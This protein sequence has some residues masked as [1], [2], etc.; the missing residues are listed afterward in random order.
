MTAVR[1]TIQIEQVRVG[2]LGL[3][4]ELEIPADAAAL[5]LFAHGSG[6]S[7]LS[8]RNRRV[9]QVLQ[10][11]GQATLLFDLLTE[12]EAADRRNVFDVA[13]LGGRVEQALDWVGQ[14]SAGA[15][16]GAIARLPVGL[17]GASTG[18]AAALVAAA[19]QPSRV[20]AV[21]SR[22]G[23]PDLAA[24]CL[25]R[26]EAPTLLIV[27]G[28]DPQVLDLNR[29]ALRLLGCRMSSP[30]WLRAGSTATWCAGAMRERRRDAVPSAD[31]RGAGSMSPGAIGGHAF[32]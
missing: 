4:G 9:A 12:R 25:D 8:E 5:V 17:F 28:A 6:S 32:R 14:Q 2:A 29:A 24:H 22:G 30:S 18:V 11:H 26:V 31:P 10:R 13:L 20:G 7:R 19:A 15:N 1:A 3:P 27:G 16:F 23:R 21:V